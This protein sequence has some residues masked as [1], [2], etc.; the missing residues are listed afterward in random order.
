MILFSARGNLWGP[1]E[2][3]SRR[4]TWPHSDGLIRHL[5]L[6]TESVGSWGCRGSRAGGVNEGTSLDLIGKW[7]EMGAYVR[8]SVQDNRLL[9]GVAAECVGVCCQLIHPWQTRPQSLQLCWLSPGFPI[10]VGLCC[11]RWGTLESGVAMHTHVFIYIYIWSHYDLGVE[12][13]STSLF[14][15]SN[16]QVFALPSITFASMADS[17]V[18]TIQNWSHV[19]QISFFL[20]NRTEVLLTGPQTPS[21]VYTVVIFLSLVAC[22]M[23]ACS[24]MISFSLCSRMFWVLRSPTPVWLRWSKDRALMYSSSV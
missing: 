7:D 17:S 15:N 1:P 22:L 2:I 16:L 11:I 19:N 10:R 8:Y 12:Q 3:G 6:Q 20:F 4:A 23:A 14:P 5:L 21:G 18:L 13:A 24:Q 9:S